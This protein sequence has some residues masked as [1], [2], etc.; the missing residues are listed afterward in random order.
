MKNSKGS[1][2]VE[3]SMVFSV[4]FLMVAAFVYLFVIMYQYVN[5]QS[6]AN[7]AATKGAYYYV[8]QTSEKY[9]SYK[10]NEMYWRMYDTSKNKKVSAISDYVNK[11]LNNSIL[12]TENNITVNTN[13][14]ILMKNLRIEI[15]EKYPLPVGNLF[16]IFG[17]SPVL[18]LKA[19]STSPL[20]DNAEFIRNLDI[21]KDIRNCIQNSDNKWI[22]ED[23]KLEDIIDKMLK[24]N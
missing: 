3:A 16:D 22:G 4:V 1:F 18:S 5:A 8:N 6:V 7:E 19:V 10:I 9:S 14:K 24:K 12:L 15:Q 13:S 11:L 2:T 20:D 17:L 21:V 23:S